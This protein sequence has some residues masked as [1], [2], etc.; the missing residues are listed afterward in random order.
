MTQGVMFANPNLPDLTDR[1]VDDIRTFLPAAPIAR[2]STSRPNCWHRAWDALA[3]AA[4]WSRKNADVLVD[5]HWVGGDPAKG[6]VYGYAS[7]SKRKGILALRN[8]KDQPGRI[9]IDIGKA[10]GLPEGTARSYSLRSP[11][12]SDVSREAI[13]LSV[14][15]EHT[16][17]LGP[18]G[19]LVFD[20]MPR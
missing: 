12:K 16:F 20:A 3:E 5:V 9:S 1:M 7:W 11:W 10:F 8:P 2:N 18:F 13:T 17:E 19:V 14:G 15:E 4:L 6:E